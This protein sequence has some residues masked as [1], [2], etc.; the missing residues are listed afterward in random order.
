MPETNIPYDVVDGLGLRQVDADL[1]RR[2]TECADRTLE[3][4]SFLIGEVR[5]QTT[6]LLR[7]RE[8]VRALNDLLE[9]PI[10]HTRHLEQQVAAHA[11][12]RSGI[13][14]PSSTSFLDPG[15]WKISGVATMQ[16]AKYVLAAAVDCLTIHEVANARYM[17]DLLAGK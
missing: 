8:F 1:L 14:H 17:E 3:S 13:H 10:V 2:A 7:N 4:K 12:P 6:K 5:Q 16:D 15:Q 11:N 9:G